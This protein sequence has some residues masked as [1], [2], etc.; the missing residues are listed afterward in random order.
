MDSLEVVEHTDNVT[1]ARQQAK[2]V[3]QE[4]K[5]SAL[6]HLDEGR[7][8]ET[9][10]KLLDC[11]ETSVETATK[12]KRD[13][14]GFQENLRQELGSKLAKYACKDKTYNQTMPIQNTTWKAEGIARPVRVM[15]DRPTAKIHLVEN[16]ATESECQTIMN[17]VDMQRFDGVDG[18][19]G[20]MGGTAVPWDVKSNPITTLASKM[21][22]YTRDLLQVPLSSN[23]EEQIFV[24]R[25]E[26]RG[27][28]APSLDRYETHCDGYCDGS[29]YKRKSR[30]ATFVVY[31]QEPEEGGAT[32]FENAG[33]YLIPK[34]GAATFYTYVDH[35]SDRTD[36]GFTQTSECG[37][38]EG[39]KTTI[40]YNVRY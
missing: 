21:F 34:K 25:Y 9:M 5:A 18:F 16:F 6:E 14:I 2:D 26:G 22:V 29:T 10:N 8:E 27:K 17:A 39:T 3:L 7:P 38:A 30:I 28:D 1:K 15:M 35:K 33:I 32:Q 11:I 20:S 40:T 24:M 23:D 31:C 19:Y 13:E 4:C 36:T 37:V 12:D